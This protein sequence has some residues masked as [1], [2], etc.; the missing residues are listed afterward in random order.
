MSS[1]TARPSRLRSNILWNYASGYTSTFGLLI[2]YPLAIHIAGAHGYGL[3]VLTFSAI[4]LFTMTDFGLG[5]GIVR[6]LALL[7]NTP[8]GHQARRQFVTVAVSIFLLIGIVLTTLF[9]TLF[10]VYLNSV[11]T[12]T[13]LASAISLLVPLAAGTLF[14]SIAGRAFN[15]VLWAEDRPDIER[16]ASLVSI[17]ARAAGYGLVLLSDGGLIGVVMVECFTLA[18]PPIVC[19]IAVVRRYGRPAFERAAFRTFG[20]PLLRLSSVL[21]LG[22]F[23]LLAAFQIPLYVVGATMG[24]TAVTAFGGLMRIYQSCRLLTS[25]AANPFIHSISTVPENKLGQTMLNCLALAA[26][27]GALMIVPLAVIPWDILDAWLGQNFVFAASAAAAVS[28]GVFSDVIVQVSSLVVNLRGSAWRI[29]CANFAML[30]LTV[31]LVLWAAN[32]Q[33]VFDTMLATVSVQLVA[34]PIYLHWALRRAGLQW[35]SLITRASVTGLIAVLMLAAIVA[36]IGAGLSGWAAV[37]AAALVE[38]GAAACAFLLFRR[39]RRAAAERQD[40][41][42]S[43]E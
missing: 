27:I 17:I 15:A 18:I 21:F 14:L 26:S 33:D 19:V 23:S 41:A 35:R 39:S 9:L 43:V 20:L 25:W 12:D 38:V 4:Q 16:K 5:T 40:Q 29:S 34:A 31:P 42:V 13:S 1:T 36:I 28:L 22:T 24:L 11:E 3:W 37:L 10:P 8:E 2:L 32:T 7:P 6:Q 30:L